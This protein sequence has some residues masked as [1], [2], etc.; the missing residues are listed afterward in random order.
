[1]YHRLT[2]F[3]G[4]DN[5]IW[6]YNTNEI[7]EGVNP[8]ETHYPGHD[9]VDIIATDVYT[10]GFNQVNYDTILELAGNKPIALGE[11]GQEPCIEIIEA[12]PRWSWFMRWSMPEGG[13]KGEYL[14]KVYQSDRTIALKNLPWVKT[15]NPKVH[16]P[17]LKD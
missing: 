17:I 16:F 9:Y 14:S 6:V 15:K 4:L 7:K 12:Q 11:V 5:L 8:H 10:E 2:D 13:K 3:H 1:M